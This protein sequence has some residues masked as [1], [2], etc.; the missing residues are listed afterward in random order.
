MGGMAE[1]V[2]KLLP[3]LRVP[4]LDAERRFY[5][6]FGLRTTYAGEEFPDFLAIG[7]DAVEFGLS[8]G[9]GIDPASFQ[10]QLGVS[11]VDAVVEVCEVSG[12]DYRVE[13]EEPGDGWLYRVVK[14]RAPGGAEVWFE[15][16]PE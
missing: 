8:K 11:D 10:W 6:S 12:W 3:I 7:N 5:E 14:V 1:L 9:D 15:G 16:D 13:V 4:D 2:T